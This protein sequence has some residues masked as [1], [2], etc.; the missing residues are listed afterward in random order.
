MF[1]SRNIKTFKGSL[2]LINKITA[3]ILLKWLNENK[4][5]FDQI[6]Y[7]KPWGNSVTYID[8]KMDSIDNFIKTYS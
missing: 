4:I 5:P 3:P 7:G 8:D 6:Y 2:G 1:T